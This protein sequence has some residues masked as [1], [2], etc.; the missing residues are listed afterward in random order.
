MSLLRWRPGAL[1]QQILSFGA[2]EGIARG[3]NWGMMAM[4]PFFLDSTSE[5]GKVG[6]IVSIEMLIASVSLL[7]M[8][9]AILRFYPKDENPGQLLRA[10]LSIWA[11]LAWIPFACVLGLYFAGVTSFFSIPLAPHLFILSLIVAISNLN[12]L[13]ISVG[14]ATGNLGMFLRFRLIF[15]GCKFV[16]VIVLAILLGHDV[17]YLLGAGLAAMMML[18]LIVPD[19][20]K[21]VSPPTSHAAVLPLFIFGWPF[22]FHILSGNILS[23][24]SRFFLEAYSTPTDVGVFTFAFTLGSGLYVGYAALSTYFEP[25][26]YSHSD[27]MARCEKWL[28][29]YTN[30]C[31]SFAAAVGA[32]TL[33]F[34]PYW[35]SYLHADYGD[36]LPT[37]SMVIGTILLNPLY[38]Q[39][40][41]RLAAHKKTGYIAVASFLSACI[42]LALNFLLIPRY[43]I[44]GA[45]VA[46]YIANIA[47][48]AIIMGTSIRVTRVPLR[49]QHAIPASLI[50]VVASMTTLLFANVP[51]VSILTLVIVSIISTSHLLKLLTS[52]GKSTR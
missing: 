27:E 34:F 5:Y 21:R 45:A 52:L 30:A 41:Y 46:M 17:S 40:N 2:G 10:V 47:L 13:C 38:L 4:L 25:K 51:T 50:C 26:I 20:R 8:D 15:A 16:S 9:R 14:R 11:G 3:L 6:L 22:V 24:F 18:I 12:I 7:G 32:M 37:I 43:G 44:W 48:C 49:N 29:F 31:V 39:G 33:F 42:S 1:I 35:S 36:S 19:L 23:Y 28:A